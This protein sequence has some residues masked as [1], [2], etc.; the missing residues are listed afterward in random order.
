M[1]KVIREQF[2]KLYESTDPLV[3][4]TKAAASCGADLTDL[5]LPEKGELNL[6]LVKESPFFF[7]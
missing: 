2:V 7:C 1:H 5:Y 6:Q 3:E 4:I